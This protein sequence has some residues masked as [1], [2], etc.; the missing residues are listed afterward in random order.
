MCDPTLQTE[1]Q[2]KETVI[3]KLISS[4]ESSL[5]VAQAWQLN[6]FDQHDDSEEVALTERVDRAV[7]NKIEPELKKQAELLKKE[8][9]DSAFQQGYEAGL[10]S[11]SEEGKAEAIEAEA[12]AQ[13]AILE[14]LLEQISQLI[15]GME[16][17]YKDIQDQ[18]LSELVDL[19]L[20]VA[21]EVTGKV[22]SDEREWILNAVQQAVQV[23][24]DDKEA[25]QVELHPDDIT[26]LEALSTDLPTSFHI[27]VNAELTPGTCMVLQGHASVLNSWQ[28]RFNEVSE[29]LKSKVMPAN[30]S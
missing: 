17:P 3:T 6:N 21:H 30:A 16:G 11:G 20:H 14:P 22:I 24:P 2:V 1:D 15:S 19:A 9:Y 12:L 4:K 25:F 27:K 23:L 26:L 10:L 28:E 18:I 7:K 13:K 29:E 5:P 8:A